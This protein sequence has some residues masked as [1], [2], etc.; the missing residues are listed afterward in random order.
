M[1]LFVFSSLGRQATTV[2]SPYEEFNHQLPPLILGHMAEGHGEHYINLM[3]ASADIL[4]VNLYVTSVDILLNSMI[5][6]VAKA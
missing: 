4:H 1:N 5:I 6:S 2:V 3:K